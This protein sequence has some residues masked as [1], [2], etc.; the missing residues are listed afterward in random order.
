MTNEFVLKIG[1]GGSR[2]IAGLGGVFSQAIYEVSYA[3]A[4]WFLRDIYSFL[5][6]K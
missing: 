2:K 6:Y 3:F 1:R 4:S 5:T